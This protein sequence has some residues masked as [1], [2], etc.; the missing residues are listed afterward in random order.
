MNTLGTRLK[1]I[2][3]NNKLTIED[4]ANIFNKKFN[5]TVGKGSI[6][7]WENDVRIPTLPYL[8]A[9]AIFFNISLDYIAG[10]NNSPSSIKF[11]DTKNK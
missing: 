3:L 4:L 5:L 8:S 9:Y 7:R 1:N 11:I 2:R 6:S 10:I